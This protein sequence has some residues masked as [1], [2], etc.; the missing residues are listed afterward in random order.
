M[1]T[2]IQ[3]GGWIS[4]LPERYRPFAILARLDRPIGVWLLLLPALWSIAL[5]SAYEGGLRFYTFVAFFLFAIGAV[6]M[7]AAGCVI[8]DLWDRKLDA[9]VVR[10]KNRPLASGE[11]NVTDAL[12]FLSI[13]LMCGFLVLLLLS[14]TAIL[15]GLVSV[16]LIII[17][18]FMK[19]VTFLP[20]AILGLTFNFGALMGWAA[21]TDSLSLPSLFLYIAGF[22]W[23][24]AYD[25][26]YAHQ[27]KEDD[28]LIGV[29]STALLFAGESK[30]WVSAFFGITW[31]CLG[32]AML[33][34]GVSVYTYFGWVLIGAHFIWQ[35]IR[36]GPDNAESSLAVFK[37]NRDA[38]LVMFLTLLAAAAMA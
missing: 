32:L 24:M 12:V 27:D 6:V 14:P 20:Q 38:G 23:T 1:S 28:V 4:R 8:N 2:D 13:L 22:F 21:M 36:W 5:A 26:I 18:P 10:T 9:Q 19:R 15:L 7:R 37:S 11:V 17:Y 34:S 30:R 16:P 33:F 35:I 31:I 29:K 3:A 25:T